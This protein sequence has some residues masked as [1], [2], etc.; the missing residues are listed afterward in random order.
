MTIHLSL[1]AIPGVNILVHLNGYV[2]TPLE[3]FIGALTPGTKIALTVE[4]VGNVEHQCYT[5][6]AHMNRTP[7]A[8]AKFGYTKNLTVIKKES[9][10]GTISSQVAGWPNNMLCLDIHGKTW[11]I[12]IVNQNGRYFFVIEE[13]TPPIEVN[14]LSPIGMVLSVSLLR[15]MATIHTGDAIFNA[16]AH[17]SHWPFRSDKGLRLL[18]RGEVILFREDKLLSLDSDSSYRY[19]VTDCVLA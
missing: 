11:N 13:W 18:N 17:W 15:G 1:Y 10:D 6:D 8:L 3:G 4:V 9:P 12:G 5:L 19:E 14:E 16:R 2:K 7:K